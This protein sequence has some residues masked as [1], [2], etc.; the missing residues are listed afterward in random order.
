M[1]REGCWEGRENMLGCLCLRFY[2][3][4]L[5]FWYNGTQLSYLQVHYCAMLLE[6]LI[7]S[8]FFFLKSHFFMCAEIFRI[9]HHVQHIA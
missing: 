8:G 7:H 1:G 2:L 4:R 6:I 5:S 3:P 9:F